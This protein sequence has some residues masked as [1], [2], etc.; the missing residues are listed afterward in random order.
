MANIP[1]VASDKLFGIGAGVGYYKG[2]GAI[3]V[4]ISGQNRGK[5][6]VYKGSVSLG[7]KSDIGVAAGINISLGES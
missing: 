1:Q 5:N 3:A 2:E 4:G 7:T 6:V